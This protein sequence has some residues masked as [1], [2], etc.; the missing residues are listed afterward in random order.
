AEACKTRPNGYVCLLWKETVGALSNDIIA[1][2][3]MWEFFKKHSLNDGNG[4]C[5]NGICEPDKCTPG[6][7]SGAD[8]MP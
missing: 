5:G 6:R 4:V 7:E 1:N 8:A 3:A 2:D